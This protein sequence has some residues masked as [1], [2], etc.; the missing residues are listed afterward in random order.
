M[1][2]RCSEGTPKCLMRQS[3]GVWT[4]HLLRDLELLDDAHFV[5]HLNPALDQFHLCAVGIRKAELV[6]LKFLDQRRQVFFLQNKKSLAQLHSTRSTSRCSPFYQDILKLLLFTLPGFTVIQL[7]GVLGVDRK[8]LS[9]YRL[10]KSKV[11]L[12]LMC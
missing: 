6:D 11:V 5:V 12:N 10:L 9:S 7:F 3:T 8:I 2:P 1:E 4:N